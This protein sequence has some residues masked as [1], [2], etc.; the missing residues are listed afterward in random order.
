MPSKSIAATSAE[1]GPWHDVADLGDDVGDRPPGLQD[2]RRIGGD[3][4]EEP[5]LGKLADFG[6]VG[7]VDKEFHGASGKVAALRR[8]SVRASLLVK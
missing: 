4:V 7:R 6:D 3:A 2:E 1:T 8:G 5:G